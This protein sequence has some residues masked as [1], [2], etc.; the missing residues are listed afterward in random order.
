LC[1]AAGLYLKVYLKLWKLIGVKV[2]INS[3]DA[4]ASAIVRI[5]LKVSVYTSCCVSK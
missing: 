4:F 2:R 1:G 5:V 3:H